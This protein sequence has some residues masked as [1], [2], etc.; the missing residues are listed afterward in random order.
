LHA[1][2]DVSN[3]KSGNVDFKVLARTFIDKTKDVYKLKI[4]IRNKELENAD[5]LGDREMVKKLRM[6]ESTLANEFIQWKRATKKHYKVL[7]SSQVFILTL[8]KSCVLSFNHY[9]KTLKNYKQ[10]SQNC[11]KRFSMH[12][13]KPNGYAL[14]LIF[15]I[16]QKCK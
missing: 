9:R 5:R 10:Q 13:K 14:T 1:T 2:F 12:K 16:S 7:H 8:I 15:K 4:A 11:N 6:E 3:G